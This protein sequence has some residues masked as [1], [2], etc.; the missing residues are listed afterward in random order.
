[1]SENKF[2][3]NLSQPPR[4]SSGP[5][6]TTPPSVATARPSTGNPS[7]EYD[8]IRRLTDELSRHSGAIEGLTVLILAMNT[9]PQ[10]ATQDELKQLLD[11]AR[12][13]VKYAP[14]A[15]AVAALLLPELTKGMPSVV[16]IK[17]AADAGAAGIAQA[18]SETVERIERAGSS[19]AS[20]IEWAAR[21]RADVLASRIGFTSWRSAGMIFGGF[22]VLVIGAIF[23]NQVREADLAQARAETKAVRGFTDWVKTQP[24]GKRLYERYYHP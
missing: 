24:E 8:P 11:E 12:A 20:R 7:T 16:A 17:A 13:G 3:R 21:S 5:P 1:M 9:R 18:G 10:A 15:G 23:A 6:A 22:L 14:D 4:P 19:A 2:L